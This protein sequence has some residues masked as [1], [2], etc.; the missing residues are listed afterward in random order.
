MIKYRPCR[1]HPEGSLCSTRERFQDMFTYDF[2]K[3]YRESEDKCFE[4]EGFVL[5]KENLIRYRSEDIFHY[6][7]QIYKKNTYEGQEY[8]K[9][10]TD[11]Y[12]IFL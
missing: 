8:K 10:R 11:K 9:R 2:V 5:I 12:Y 1:Y 4:F 7:T 6:R 3:I